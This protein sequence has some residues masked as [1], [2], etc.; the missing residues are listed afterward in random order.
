MITLSWIKQVKTGDSVPTVDCEGKLCVTKGLFLA[1]WKR[2]C[3]SHPKERRFHSQRGSSVRHARDHRFLL[4]KP[5]R[6]QKTYDVCI[7][8]Q[9]ILVTARFS[10]P[11]TGRSFFSNGQ[12]RRRYIRCCCG[13]FLAVFVFTCRSAA[14]RIALLLCIATVAVALLRPPWTTPITATAPWTPPKTWPSWG[15]PDTTTTP[16]CRPR[17]RPISTRPPLNRPSMKSKP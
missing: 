4:S 10:A 6:C 8:I 3:C 5:E 1:S 12:V 16:T 14:A 17:I 7:M 11:H 15:H 13:I 2:S 9:F